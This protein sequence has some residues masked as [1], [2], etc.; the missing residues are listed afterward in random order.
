MKQLLAFL[1]LFSTFLS[2]AAQSPTDGLMM[3]KGTL[4]SMVG[5]SNSR[6][7]NY[8]EGD[9]NAQTAISALLLRKM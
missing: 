1:L 9:K 4:C 7:D 2:A 3:P 5:Y 6:W 8:W